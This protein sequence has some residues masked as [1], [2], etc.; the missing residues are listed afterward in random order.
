M[1]PNQSE[2]GGLHPDLVCLLG[3]FGQSA[4]PEVLY[5]VVCPFLAVWLASLNGVASGGFRTGRVGLHM[6]RQ[7]Y[8]FFDGEGGSYACQG[9]CESI[10]SSFDF[11][12]RPLGESL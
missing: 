6:Y 10:F 8:G 5:N 12:D 3:I 7:K 4:C 1:P 2:T 11:F 9:V